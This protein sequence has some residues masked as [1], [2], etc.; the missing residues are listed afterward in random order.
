MSD[1]LSSL[2]ATLERR[3]G[4]VVAVAA[5]I[6]LALLVP[7]LTLAPEVSASTEPTGDV[8]IARDRIDETFISSVHPMF[9]IVEADNGDLLTA[10]SLGAL[11]GAE[12]ALRSDDVL[13]ANLFTYYDAESQTDVNGVVTL[14]DLVD[15]ELRAAGVD[16]IAGATD[17]EVKAA[18]SA[19]IDTLG[20]RS[21]VLGIS[22][23]SERDADGL[24][25]V[26]AVNALVL[27]D[28]DALG[29]GNVS[30]TLGGDTDVEEYDREIQEMFRVDGLQANG[31]AIDV[32][33]T[34]QEQGA[35]AGPFIGFTILAVLVLVGLTFRSYWVLATVSVAFLA[36]IVWLKGISNLIGLKDDLVLSLIVPVAM[37]SFGVDF[38]F[39]AIGRYREERAEGLGARGALVTS[40]TAV[41]GA[42]IL[43]LI[44]DAT[45]FLSNLTSGIESINQFGIG[46]AIA[47]ASA[48]L[49]LGVVAPLVVA[50]IEGSVPAPTPGARSTILRLVA[51]V[52]AASLTMASVLFLVFV[53][54]AVGAVLA[55]VTALVV[56][57]VPF[58]VLRRRSGGRMGDTAVAAS[59]GAMARPV[60]RAV[61]ALAGR[62]LIMISAAAVVTGVAATFALQVPAEFDVEDFFATDTDFVVGLDQ[63]DAHVGDRGGEPALLYVEGDLTDPERLA[64]LSARIDEV[65][66]LDTEF[67][68]RGEDGVQVDGGIFEIF[69]AT[70]SSPAMQG[71]VVAETGVALTDDNGDAIPDTTEQIEALFAVASANGVPLDETRLLLTPDDVNTEVV[72][73]GADSR[74]VFMMGVVDSRAQESVTASRAA[75]EPIAEAIADD[76]GGSFVQVTGS[77]FVREASLEATNRALQV[78]LPV[79]VLLCLIVATVFLRSLRYGLAA[80]V[81]ILMVVA[82]LY[83]VMY[84][85]GYAINLV[86]ATIAAVSIG[87]GI[88]FAIHFIVRYRE[89]LGRHGVRA[90]AVRI[91]GEGT[92]LALVASAISSAIGFGILALA[93]MPLFAAYGLLTALMIL[94]ALVATLAVL[95]SIL[96]LVTSDA[97]SPASTDAANERTDRDGAGPIEVGPKATATV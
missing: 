48:Y 97:A 37:I 10:E 23:Q 45:A 80:I 35:V 15:A 20:E 82:W 18:G 12:E 30:V 46:A 40:M 17:A 47:L 87:I 94:M 81:P 16:G 19:I 49:L 42:L 76:F 6:T 71:F 28:N 50:R 63:L 54:P 64:D 70:W 27:S 85:A 51:G 75:L 1:N 3:T 91:S 5:A 39:H 33:L 36:L 41:S 7:F 38:A 4:L 86:T 62:P 61:A 83:A 69:D 14:A 67:L 84:L 96:V 92:G 22:S 73:D 72:L 55:V 11:L 25:T 53:L 79:A 32:N 26:P 2:Y 74:T 60:G 65:R 44:S 66:A 8:F 95:P 77:A 93:P 43:A 59:D 29:F 89:E 9:L 34:S 13:G 78:S 31:V 56:L 88:D 90:T 68:A 58:L 52:G 57:V 21:D 24:W